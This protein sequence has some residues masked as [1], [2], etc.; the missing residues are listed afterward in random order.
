MREIRAWD[1]YFVNHQSSNA[2]TGKLFITLYSR[3]VREHGSST[4]YWFGFYVNTG[5]Q[6]VAGLRGSDIK[7]SANVYK[8]CLMY[9]S[10]VNAGNIVSHDQAILF[11]FRDYVR[12]GDR[13]HILSVVRESK[14][15]E[16]EHILAILALK[17]IPSMD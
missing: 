13:Q 2:R 9:D 10:W 17:P 3:P 12:D 5:E 8:N 11:N 7:L 15:L 14:T 4:T 16:Q 6:R 1:I